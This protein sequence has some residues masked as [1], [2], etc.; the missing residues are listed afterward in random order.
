VAIHSGGHGAS[1]HAGSI[2]LIDPRSGPD[3]RPAMRTVAGGGNYRDPWALSDGLFLAAEGRRIVL[4]DA[5]GQAVGLYQCSL[6]E[7]AAGLMCHEPRPLAP[8]SRERLIAPRVNLSQATGR[9]VL[10]DATAGRNMAGVKPGEIRKLL[11]LES[12]P[13]P[14]NYTGGMDPL[15]YGGT[16]TLE[17][18]VGTVPVEPDGSA[19]FEAPALRSL[20]FVA[21]DEHN[22]SVKRMQ[23]FCTVQP[24]ETIGCVGCH[25][26]RSQAPPVPPFDPSDG[27]DRFDRSHRSSGPLAL[28]R[29]PSRI[30]PIEGCPDVFDFPRDI[31]PVL[32]KLCVAC[33]DYVARPSG[34]EIL[35]VGDAGHKAN[36]PRA[37]PMPERSRSQPTAARCSHTPTSP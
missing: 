11:V 10:M 12:L 18:V 34:A 9:L 22:L 35:R 19:Y 31:Q 37:A 2:V 14:I 29:P 24:G 32:D 16:F 8:R 15:S 3:A 20:F 1:E 17:R 25:E 30:E 6:Q 4:V 28:L 26:S 33:H 5:K 27:S 13:K 36:P 21:L 23:S 7:A